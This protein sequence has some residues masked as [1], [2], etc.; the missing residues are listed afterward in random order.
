[1]AI[2]KKLRF[3]VV[4]LLIATIGG[5]YYFF[6]KKEAV[7]QAPEDDTLKMAVNTCEGITERSASHLVAIVEFQKL[8]IAGRKARVYQ[9]CMQ[10]HGYIENPE[11][12]TYSAPLAE[13]VAKETSIS[14]DEALENLRRANMVVAKHVQ[15]RP[16]YWTVTKKSNA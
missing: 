9:L 6:S 7:V 12:L 15:G 2:L 3:Y 4:L 16:P 5:F 10:D 1:M 13:K 14:V 11:W 8:E